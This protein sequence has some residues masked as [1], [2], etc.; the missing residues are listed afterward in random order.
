MVYFWY[1]FGM[2]LDRDDSKSDTLQKNRGFSFEKVAQILANDYFAVQ[3]ND[4][5]EQFA[6]IGFVDGQLITLI[7]EFRDFF[8][9]EIIWLVTYWKST[10]AEV[11][12]YEDYK[13]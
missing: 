13:K 3:K 4:D 9:Q 2:K 8:D 11:R 12:K 6:A 1:I 7:Y 10:K 5:P